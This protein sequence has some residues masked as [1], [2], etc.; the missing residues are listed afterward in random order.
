[1][2]V[3]K[4]KMLI[5]YVV[6]I[7]MLAACENE[8][9]VRMPPAFSL[10]TLQE[11]TYVFSFDTFRNPDDVVIA[12][13]DTTFIEANLEYLISRNVDLSR[14]DVIVVWRAMDEIPFIRRIID[15]K[16]TG[17]VLRLTTK[18]ADFGSVFQDADVMFTS[19]LKIFSSNPNEAPYIRYTNDNICHPAVVITHYNDGK[20]VATSADE[21]ISENPDWNILTY[22]AVS[23]LDTTIVSDGVIFDFNRNSV[24]SNIGLE[25]ELTVQNTL[26]RRFE[27]FSMGASSI[28]AT[29]SFSCQTPTSTTFNNRFTTPT[30]Y[31]LIYWAGPIPVAISVNQE[32]RIYIDFKS[33]AP[34]AFSTNATFDSDYKIGLAYRSGWNPI[35]DVSLR[36]QSDVENVNLSD[37]IVAETS[38][39]AVN[40]S[41][42]GIYNDF[43]SDV[44]VGY[45]I[46][47]SWDTIVENDKTFA[48]STA[49]FIFGGTVSANNAITAW[50]IPKW[51]EPFNVISTLAWDIRIPLD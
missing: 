44:T 40:V 3:V 47:S 25:V 30:S 23:G 31:T 16:N 28:V 14:G 43:Y 33:D 26:L 38:L 17:T 41:K 37:R 50:E 49:E 32:V 6:V 8:E 13:G 2:N 18:D 20:S 35:R 48:T 51:S 9:P 5:C 4:F 10:P 12:S 39:N 24:V 34:I 21:L 42:V 11:G 46:S 27:C 1:M 22:D 19:S 7:L 15:K 36:F 29:N 45:A